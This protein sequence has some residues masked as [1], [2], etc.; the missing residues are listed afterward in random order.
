MQ[1]FIEPQCGA[2]GRRFTVWVSRLL[3]FPGRRS[4][5]S[6][7]PLIF[8]TDLFVREPLALTWSRSTSQTLVKTHWSAS[9]WGVTTQTQLLHFS[10]SA[11]SFFPSV[12]FQRFHW[13]PDVALA[14]CDARRLHW[15]LGSGANWVCVWF[16]MFP[17]FW[18][19]SLKHKEL[20]FPPRLHMSVWHKTFILRTACWC[21]PDV[22]G[23]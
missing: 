10:L 22:R 23:C 7:P 9:R 6:F 8:A 21:L 18:C 5:T 2:A 3:F 4:S 16:L 17:V 1:R 13:M 20:L 14:L 11:P 15:R 12:I 19:D